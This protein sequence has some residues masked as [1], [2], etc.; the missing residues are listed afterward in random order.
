MEGIF[1]KE[2][3]RKRGLARDMSETCQKWEKEQDCAESVSD[4]ELDNEESL[5]FRMKMGFVCR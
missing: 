5:K 2:E 1:I 3:Y 4:C